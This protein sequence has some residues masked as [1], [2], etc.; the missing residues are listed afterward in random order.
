MNSVSHNLRGLWHSFE[1]DIHFLLALL[2]DVLFLLGAKLLSL[3]Q[4]V[5]VQV[6]G[7]YVSAIPLDKSTIAVQSLEALQSIKSQTMWVIVWVVLMVLLFALFFIALY[8]VCNYLIW[9][10]LLRKK[11][12][13]VWK[14]FWRFY[15]LNLV[16]FFILGVFLLPW[17]ALVANAPDSAINFLQT[18]PWLSRIVFTVFGIL[19]VLHP[20]LFLQSSFF[21][22]Q[23][24]WKT[25]GGLFTTGFGNLSK[26]IIQYLLSIVVS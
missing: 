23:R 15:L 3:A 22:N 4:Q 5:G 16:W 1:L 8:S 20:L 21:K 10:T 11:G 13:G 26:H 14:Q 19:V 12:V 2:F 25:I 18:L 9:I 7:A 17:I 24:V 6:L